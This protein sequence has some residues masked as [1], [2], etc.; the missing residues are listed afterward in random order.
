[1]LNNKMKF[2]NCDKKKREGCEVLTAVNIPTSKEGQTYEVKSLK[3]DKRSCVL[4][5][6]DA[7]ESDGY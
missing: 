1:M 2:S 3:L 4:N 6:C 7:E 5:T